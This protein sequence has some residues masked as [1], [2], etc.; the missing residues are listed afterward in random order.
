MFDVWVNTPTKGM[1]GGWSLM[2]SGV[3]LEQARVWKLTCLF[4]VRF[5]A[6]QPKEST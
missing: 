6:H 2:A 3:T 5:M 1:V 4:P